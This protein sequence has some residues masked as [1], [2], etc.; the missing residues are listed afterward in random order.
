[1]GQTTA[2]KKSMRDRGG[3]TRRV[4]SREYVLRI[5]AGVVVQSGTGG[6]W[7]E[8]IRRLSEELNQINKAQRVAKDGPKIQEG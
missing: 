1:M 5:K 4:V 7:T 6:D 8:R 2:P 3:K